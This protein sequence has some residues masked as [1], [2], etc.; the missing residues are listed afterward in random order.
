MKETF[1]KCVHVRKSQEPRE[2]I[3]KDPQL[4]QN[5]I[6]K[7]YNGEQNSDSILLNDRCVTLQFW[8]ILVVT[9]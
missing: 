7:Q 4:N 1:L 8:E 5:F 9:S 2:D 3:R 6:I